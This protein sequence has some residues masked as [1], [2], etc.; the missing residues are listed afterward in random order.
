ML[1]HKDS[2]LDHALSAAHLSLVL[3]KLA[4]RD[5]FFIETIELPDELA[6]VPCGLFGPLMGDAPIGDE[7]VELKHRGPRTWLS[8]VIGREPRMVRTLT[9]I[10]GPHN[11]LP[12]V[13]YTAF[14]G[15][16]TPQEPGD[17][18]CKGVEASR[19]FWSHHALAGVSK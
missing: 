2:H 11:G 12:C 14:G 19:E 1:I 8:R 5:G 18:S 3:S 16:S 13:L 9:V 7:E 4:D 15:P 6:S 10:A 17:P